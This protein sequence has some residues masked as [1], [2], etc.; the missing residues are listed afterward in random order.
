VA[1]AIVLRSR[2]TL[3]VYPPVGMPWVARVMKIAV[4]DRPTDCVATA[5]ASGR[6][7]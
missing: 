5:D 3:K 7:K 6:Q 2:P 4:S 1:L